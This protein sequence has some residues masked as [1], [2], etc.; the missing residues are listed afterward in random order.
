M[1]FLQTDDGVRLRLSDRGEGTPAIVL[2]HG[3]KGSHRLWDAATARLSDTHRT[4]AFDLRGMGESDKPRA[5]YDFEELTDDLGAVLRGLG[6]REVVLVGWSM[7]CTVA[8][9][10][11]ERGGAGVAG[12]VLVNGPLRLTRTSDFPHAMTEGELDA[13]LAQLRDRWPVGE[14][15]FQSQTVLG[16]DPALIDWLYG[17][18]LQ[19]PL[20]VALRVVRNQAALDMREVLARLK[21]PVLA[22][23]SRQDPYYPVSL[24]D[25]IADRAPQGRRTIFERSAHC[26]PIEEAD[27]FCE[28]VSQFATEVGVSAS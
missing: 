18:A 6:L 27:R 17:I 20:D 3:W 25:Y 9:R 5:A 7:G 26:L 2:V 8:L 11:L 10:Y 22:L 28:L 4:V 12:L 24:A 15:E 13:H 23:Y 14:R 19:T 16:S 21:M 1:S